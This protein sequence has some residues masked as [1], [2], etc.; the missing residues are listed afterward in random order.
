[1][2]NKLIMVFVGLGVML[3]GIGEAGDG[4]PYPLEDA[5]VGEWAQYNTQMAYEDDRGRRRELQS[6]MKVVAVDGEGDEKKVTIEV[7]L[8]EGN[9]V[10][11]SEKNVLG[12]KDIDKVISEAREVTITRENIS[13]N[14]KSFNAHVVSL[15]HS[16]GEMAKSEMKL[17]LSNEVPVEGIIKLVSSDSPVPI[18]ELVDYG[19]K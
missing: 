10:R 6:L 14:G 15:T 9:M 18:M 13:V 12:V 16:R 2:L 8:I 1:M 11:R 19:T 7:G 5:K 17:Y 3:S 4:V